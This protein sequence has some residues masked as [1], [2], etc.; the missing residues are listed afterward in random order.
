V[1]RQLWG[2]KADTASFGGRAADSAE[3][4]HK[5]SEAGRVKFEALFEPLLGELEARLSGALASLAKTA[6]EALESRSVPTT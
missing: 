6:A 2:E 1:V 4:A 5:R 3:A